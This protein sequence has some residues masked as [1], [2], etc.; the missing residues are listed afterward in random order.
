M[1]KSILIAFLIAIIASLLLVKVSQHI[2]KETME[3][4]LPPRSEIDSDLRGDKGQRAQYAEGKFILSDIAQVAGGP[5]DGAIVRS[6]HP[7]PPSFRIKIIGDYTL[8]E[9][10]NLYTSVSLQTKGWGWRILAFLMN[11]AGIS[12]AWLGGYMFSLGTENQPGAPVGNIFYGIIVVI[13]GATIQGSV[14]IIWPLKGSDKRST[15]L[16]QLTAQQL[17]GN[18]AMYGAT[19]MAVLLGRNITDNPAFFIPGILGVLFLASINAMSAS[20]TREIKPSREVAKFEIDQSSAI[21]EVDF[22][23]LSHLD[24]ACPRG[25]NAPNKRTDTHI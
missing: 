15:A 3:K 24:R 21:L 16:L 20:R 11:L 10:N 8:D 6:A 25:K 12:L 1:K 17:T 4:E 9:G 14:N 7:L 22:S 5:I 18:I 23:P 2:K 19:L 13:I